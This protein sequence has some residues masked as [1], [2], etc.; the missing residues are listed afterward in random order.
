MKQWNK[1]YDEKT[2]GKM[3]K[4]TASECQIKT[5]KDETKICASSIEDIIDFSTFLF[6]PNITVTTANN[7]NGANENALWIVLKQSME[8]MFPDHLTLIYVPYIL[9]SCHF[10]L[11]VRMYDV[12]IL[13]RKNKTQIN[14]T[15]VI[16]HVNTFS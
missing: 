8:V 10:V 12:E 3:I 5:N 7:G 6:G 1:F 15:I 11:I 4:F 13:D 14:Q 2:L 16:C 9:Y